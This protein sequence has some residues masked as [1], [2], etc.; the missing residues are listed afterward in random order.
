MNKGIVKMDIATL[1]IETT[2]LDGYLV[3]G[4]IYFNNEHY[5]FT[6]W[7]KFFYLLHKHVP[8][9]T[10]IYAHNGGKFD[11]KFLLENIDKFDNMKISH[12]INING[13][14]IFTLTIKGKRFYFRD[15][16]LHIKKSLKKA[17]KSFD[18]KH[19]KKEFNIKQWLKDDCPITDELVEYLKYDCISLYELLQK[20][21]NIVGKPKLTIASTA[22]NI[23]MNTRYKGIEL[24][25]LLKNFLTINEEKF[26]RDSYKGG[27]TEVFKRI[28]DNAL[29]HY[30][31]NSL[32]PTVMKLREY[33]Y[34]RH[35]KVLG[36]DNSIKLINSGR[37]GIIKCAIKSP[38]VMKYPYLAKRHN[39]KLLFPLGVWI[40]TITSIEFE[41]AIGLGYEI[42]IIEGIFYAKKGHLFNEYVDK[43]YQ[44]KSNSVGAK[45]ETAKLMLN[46]AYGKFGQRRD[47]DTY[48]TYDEIMEQGIDVNDLEKINDD[49]YKTKTISYQNRKINPT[50]ATFVTAYA[51]D[52]LYQGM[53][54]IFNN[55]GTIYYC[56]TDSI[57]SDI[58]LPDN[59][60]DEKELGKWD[61]EDKP[62]KALFIS[63]KQYEYSYTNDNDEN[64]TI[65]KIKGV[66]NPDF[67]LYDVLNTDITVYGSRLTGFNEHFKLK[68]TDKNRYIGMIKT[69]KI[70]TSR[71]S[72]RLLDDDSN[73]TNPIYIYE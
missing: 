30:D 7:D 34:G 3:I 17:C 57:F 47:R 62:E 10:Q 26:I 71:L 63:P 60:I 27:R 15:S 48:Y 58:E 24:S 22:F 9:K 1:D 25:K 70:I 67:S 32:Y 65:I 52:Y 68:C 35:K 72:K 16:M 37:L 28:S 49:Y 13:C 21:F 12:F 4:D 64:E 33:P 42:E 53:E 51:R 66:T 55:G 44:I 8:D 59:M 2:G 50:I 43:F 46:S 18:V 11:Y 14:I 6:E 39:D 31:V 19:A 45:K 56:D 38:D 29:F 36:H 20:Y 54:Y 61:L 41:K 40:D 69:R 23:L 5:L 73:N